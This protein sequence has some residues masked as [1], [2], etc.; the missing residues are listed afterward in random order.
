MCSGGKPLVQQ[1]LAVVDLPAVDLHGNDDHQVEDGHGREAEDEAVGLAVAVELL[2]HREHLHGAVDERGHAEQAA[3]DHRDHQVADVV[4]GQRQEAE[5]CG[6]DAE[7]IWVLPLVRRRHHP[8]GHQVQLTDHHLAER[9]RQVNVLNTLTPG[10][11][12][13]IQ[14]N[15]N[16][17]NISVT[18]LSCHQRPDEHVD[19]V[20]FT[21]L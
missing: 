14:H 2:G 20:E 11:V 18:D 15:C 17:R 13:Y 19:N 4:P 9:R 6:D 5:G 12:Q 7:E 8:V 16:Q 21:D 3:T 10:W 1:L